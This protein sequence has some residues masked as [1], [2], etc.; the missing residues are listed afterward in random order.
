LANF[1]VTGTS[2]NH[3]ST[4][5]VFA[6]DS[7][8][9]SIRSETSQ[10]DT[11]NK[12]NIQLLNVGYNTTLYGKVRFNSNTLSSNWTYFILKTK[13][14]II[15][16]RVQAV[17]YQDQDKRYSVFGSYTYMSSSGNVLAC[18]SENP[19]TVSFHRHNGGSWSKVNTVDITL[20]L[21]VDGCRAK[22][23][24]LNYSGEKC[25]VGTGNGLIV[26]EFD[27]EVYK[28]THT[29]SCEYDATVDSSNTVGYSCSISEDGNTIAAIC[30]SPDRDN[31]IVYKYSNNEW[32][33]VKSLN[34]FNLFSLDIS[35]DGNTIAYSSISPRG[36][37]LLRNIN[38]TW[39]DNFTN[40]T[41]V[42]DAKIGH[43]VCM[44][45]LMNT[46][47]VSVSTG[48]KIGVASFTRVNNAWIFIKYTN[49]RDNYFDH[50][51]DM[52]ISSNGSI[53]FFGLSYLNSVAVLRRLQD[54]SLQ[55]Y[56][57]LQNP[58]RSKDI[59]EKKF[60]T[61]V[62]CNYS[63]TLIAVSDPYKDLPDS[64]IKDLGS[65]TYFN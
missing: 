30:H 22:N 33:I 19:Q 53:F 35:S 45:D 27:S 57:Y 3:T 43:S 58:D 26:L 28:Q 13:E 9:T 25:V 6:D 65:I 31:I 61:S 59:G 8:F 17:T 41:Y 14:N 21:R 29:L 2:V 23:V 56:G 7:S 50:D 52:D 1:T 11:V 40:Y 62:S 24:S 64:S 46:L 20:P 36:V 63:G 12:T 60:G 10:N 18:I 42:A 37:G 55:S 32:S 4:D 49:I 38:G 48:T 39:I 51:M 16:N 47:D 5:W 34:R 15:P 54:G 44:N